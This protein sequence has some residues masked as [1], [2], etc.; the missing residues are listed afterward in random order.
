MISNTR[1]ENNI[2]HMPGRKYVYM[3][4]FTFVGVSV[5]EFNWKKRK[6][7]MAKL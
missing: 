2:V 1:S 4:N 3:Q 7:N 5:M 6:K